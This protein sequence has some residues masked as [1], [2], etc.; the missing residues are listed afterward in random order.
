MVEEGGKDVGPNGPVTSM[1]CLEEEGGGLC[2]RVL[3]GGWFDGLEGFGWDGGRE[4]TSFNAT[5]WG[6]LSLPLASLRLPDVSSS[7]SPAVLQ[8]LNLSIMANTTA[9]GGASPTPTP[10]P[11]PPLPPSPPGP[12]TRPVVGINSLLRIP[13]IFNSGSSSGSSRGGTSTPG[14]TTSR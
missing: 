4:L 14:R 12:W 9:D 7:N 10:S 11:L 3:V 1:M 6:L 8:A 2:E 5:P 13:S